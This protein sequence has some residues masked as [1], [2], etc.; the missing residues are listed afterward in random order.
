MSSYF[1]IFL[2][3]EALFNIFCILHNYCRT[4]ESIIQVQ[5]M[6]VWHMFIKYRQCEIKNLV[7]TFSN[8]LSPIQRDSF[9]KFSEFFF[10]IRT[11]SWGQNISMTRF[12]VLKIF[13]ESFKF[14]E[15]LT[16]DSAVSLTSRSQ[17]P[18]CHRHTTDCQ[19]IKSIRG[20]RA[21]H[22]KTQ[23]LKNSNFLC[24]IDAILEHG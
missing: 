2:V 9:T 5:L 8:V 1:M 11:Y 20:N 21:L 22:V 14:S 16:T 12:D 3:C 10:M 19:S 4:E 24:E 23:D 7:S 6:R 15:N 18:C 13:L 17:T